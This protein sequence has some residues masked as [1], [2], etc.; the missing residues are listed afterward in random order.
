MEVIRALLKAGKGTRALPIACKVEVICVQGGGYLLLSH[1]P[2]PILID[3]GF[4]HKIGNS[5]KPLISKLTSLGINHP[6]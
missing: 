4:L 1:F 2:I 3:E 6:Q 5:R